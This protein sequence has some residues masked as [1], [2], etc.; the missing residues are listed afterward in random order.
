MEEHPKVINLA[1]LKEQGKVIKGNK[2]ASLIDIGDDVALL[3]FHSPKNAIATDIIQMINTSVK[4][5]SDNYRGLVIGNQGSTFCVGANLMLILMEAQDQN[6]PE[7]DL[8]VRQFQKTMGSLRT[9]INPW[10]PHPST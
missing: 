5:V 2:G 10:W 1:K 9:W 4:E 3:E 7:L 6:W 8:M